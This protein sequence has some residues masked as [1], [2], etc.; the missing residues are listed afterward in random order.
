MSEQDTARVERT[1]VRYK[2]RFQA[3]FGPE[4]MNISRT[5][6][7]VDDFKMF[8]DIIDVIVMNSLGKSVSESYMESFVRSLE[9][10]GDEDEVDAT[11]MLEC[12]MPVLRGMAEHVWMLGWL[13]RDEQRRE[14]VAANMKSLPND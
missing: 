13:Y 11:V 9:D 7:K 12:L 10:Q 14:Q 3:T 4:Q 2:D 6:T 5:V 8:G 1:M